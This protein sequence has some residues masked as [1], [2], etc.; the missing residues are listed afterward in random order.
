MHWKRV[1]LIFNVCRAAGSTVGRSC[2]SSVQRQS[3]R[4]GC[5]CL[6][7][8]EGWASE[9]LGL[10]LDLRARSGT[11]IFLQPDCQRDGKGCTQRAELAHLY[12]RSHQL[13]ENPHN[14]RWV[15]R[16][17]RIADWP[18]MVFSLPF[19]AL[20]WGIALSYP[21]FACFQVPSRMGESY[22]GPW[23][24]SSIASKANFMQHL[25]WSPYSPMRSSG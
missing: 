16:P 8:D 19:D 11:G 2:L 9:K 3:P 18:V 4:K 23:L 21:F 22:P 14:S 25:I 15:S 6:Y 13:R 24:W 10:S 17:H 20:N 1:V 5:F 12:I 7:T